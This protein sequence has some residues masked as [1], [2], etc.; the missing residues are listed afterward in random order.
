MQRR[1]SA[2][3]ASLVFATLWALFGTGVPT[4]AAEVTILESNDPT[5]VVGTQVNEVAIKSLPPGIRLKVLD[6]SKGTTKSL[7]GP[8]SDKLISPNSPYGGSRD[9]V[10]P[11]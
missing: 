11:K 1:E 4:L 2:L 3:R 9:I 8:E 5:F 7:S 10:P 6:L